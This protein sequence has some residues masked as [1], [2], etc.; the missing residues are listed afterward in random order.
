MAIEN[1]K[2]ERVGI[3][4]WTATANRDSIR[5]EY[6]EIS[7]EEF[8]KGRYRVYFFVGWTLPSKKLK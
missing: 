2:T 7:Q 4:T 3:Y 5:R 6:K 1:T 8:N